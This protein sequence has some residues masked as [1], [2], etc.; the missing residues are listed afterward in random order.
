MKLHF[1]IGTFLITCP[2]CNQECED[3][4]RNV[5]NS[6]GCK[7]EFQCEHCTKKF[8]VEPHVGFDSYADCELNG[9]KHEMKKSIT[10][11]NHYRCNN[12]NHYE[13]RNT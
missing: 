13:I 12:C 3:T 6:L 4:G 11:N 9:K 5:E 1:H 8:Y 7:L 2:Y 10:G